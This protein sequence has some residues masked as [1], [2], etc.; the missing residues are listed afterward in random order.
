MVGV[1]ERI[2]SS[3]FKLFSFMDF[4][5]FEFSKIQNHHETR[6][7]SRGGGGGKNFGIFKDFFTLGLMKSPRDQEIVSWWGW[8][9]IILCY[10]FKLLSFMDFI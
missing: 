9:K 4:L 8:G 2:L 5:D 10:H 1:G 6:I 3:H 7:L